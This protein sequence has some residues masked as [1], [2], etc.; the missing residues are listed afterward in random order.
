MLLYVYTSV[1][2]IFLRYILD[3][4]KLRRRAQNT[5]PDL[6]TAQSEDGELKVGDR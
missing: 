3:V 4:V 2:G 6:D 1:K 5:N